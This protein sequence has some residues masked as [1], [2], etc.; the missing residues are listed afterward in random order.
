MIYLDNAATERMSP[1]VAEAILPYLTDLYGNPS[2]AHPIG[3]DGRRAVNWARQRIGELLNIGNG[4]IIFTSGGSEANNQGLHCALEERKSQD[5]NRIIISEIE[6]DS[7]YLTAKGLAKLGF[8]VTAVGPSGEGLIDPHRIEK[9][10]DSKTALVSIMWANNEIGTIQPIEEIGKLCR[11]AGVLFH[12]DGVQAVGH[13]EVDFSALQ[14]DMLSLSAHKFGGMKGIG[15]LCVRKDITPPPLIYGGAQEMGLRGGTENVAG[16][17][18]MALALE[19][20]LTD[21]QAKQQKTKLLRDKLISQLTSLP[22]VLLNGSREHRLNG[23]IN[24]SFEGIT[25]E[26]MLL[27]LEEAG[28]CASAGAACHALN[29]NSRVLS[30]IGLSEDRAQCSVRFSINENNTDDEI[31]FL[32]NTIKKIL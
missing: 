16:I 17:V 19:E 29:P 10:L 2:S 6:H 4:S 14:V 27:K 28:I 23:N 30:A 1:S 3:R 26:A 13:T 12:S 15:A 21:F 25:A 7:V 24:V 8:E 18:S 20:K 5:K 22:R 9:L 32:Y 31:D 11:K